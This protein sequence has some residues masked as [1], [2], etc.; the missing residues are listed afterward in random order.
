MS[1]ATPLLFVKDN[2][3]WL[4]VEA[5]LAFNSIDCSLENL[6]SYIREFRW[7]EAER[8]Q[9][10]LAPR[11]HRHSF[12]FLQSTMK[13]VRDEPTKLVQFYMIIVMCVEQVL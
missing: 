1:V 11:A 2:G 12:A 5:D 6:D 4:I 8:K 13:I 7:T 10:V 3:A 9:M